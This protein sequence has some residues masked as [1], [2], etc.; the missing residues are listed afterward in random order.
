MVVIL[1]VALTKIYGCIKSVCLFRI[2]AA[3]YDNMLAVKYFCENGL[4]VNSKNRR[5]ETPLHLGR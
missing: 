2:L 1:A 4:D 3:S 5:H